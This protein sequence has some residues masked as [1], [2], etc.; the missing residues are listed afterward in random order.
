VVPFLAPRATEKQRD[1]YEQ[2]YYRSKK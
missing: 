1:V 2:H